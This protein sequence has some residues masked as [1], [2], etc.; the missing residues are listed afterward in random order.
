MALVGAQL[1]R[2]STSMD[3]KIARTRVAA[4][5][6]PATLAIATWYGAAVMAVGL[7]SCIRLL[8]G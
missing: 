7:A 2:R 4:R 3:Q 8:L 6:L 5:V 1:C